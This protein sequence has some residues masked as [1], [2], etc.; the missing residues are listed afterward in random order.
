[1][2]FLG[3]SL[4]LLSAA[5]LLLSA[6]FGIQ[7][8]RLSSAAFAALAGYATLSVADAVSLVDLFG[9]RYYFEAGA[10]YFIGTVFLLISYIAFSALLGVEQYTMP[11]WETDEMSRHAGLALLLGFGSLAFLLSDRHSLFDVWSEARTESGPL[12][13]L[14]A[15]ALLLAAPGVVSAVIASR[16]FVALLLLVVSASSFL[17]LG[18]RA[19]VIGALALLLWLLVGR[20]E[21]PGKKFRIVTIALIC[22]LAM[23]VV[24]RSL[25]GLGVG[26]ILSAIWDGSLLDVLFLDANET[27]FSGGE[28][29]IPKYF[30]Y[31]SISNSVNEFG[32]MTSVQ[33]LLLMP[34]P[35]IEGW[36]E[37][38]LDV[39][40]L[41][42]AKAFRDGVFLEYPGQE[43]LLD[44]YLNRSFGS[45]HPTLFGEYYLTGGW[46]S[47]LPSL[48]V[49]GGVFALIDLTMRRMNRLT[50]LALCGPVLIGFFFVARGNSVIGLGYFFYLFV[51]FSSLQLFFGIVA[52]ASIRW[53]R[54]LRRERVMV[55]EARPK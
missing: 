25:R 40:Y 17:L 26:G 49:V 35:R 43:I 19:A 45:L 22:G 55:N 4:F 48:V 2:I 53:K 51:I 33:R 12:T 3:I 18:S 11:L 28:S 42:W 23:H 20:A 31:A 9:G 50:S 52:A 29:S 8:Q 7:G 37:K 16:Y 15:A 44:A 21:G 27:D 5:L 36:F 24:L 30:L 38:P 54:F 14:A 47:L 41:F 13:V 39:T 6:I 46:A 34:F 10:I 1:M 32:F